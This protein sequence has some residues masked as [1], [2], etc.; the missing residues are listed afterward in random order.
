MA[1]NQFLF[2]EYGACFNSSRAKRLYTLNKNTLSKFYVELKISMKEAI[3]S[4]KEKYKQLFIC[5]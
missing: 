1:A 3:L 4:L 5:R 2:K